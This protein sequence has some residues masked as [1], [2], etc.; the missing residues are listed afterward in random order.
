M[1]TT[2]KFYD[3][4]SLLINIKQLENQ[5]IVIS[6]ITLTELENIKSSFNKDPQIKA[7]AR[8]ALRFFENNPKDY[9]VWIY[10]VDMLDPI[11]KMGLPINEDTKILATAIDYEKRQ[12]PDD[13]TFV[14]NDL[15]L[16]HMANLFFGRDS[17]E[18]VSEEYEEYNGYQE[19]IMS[20][21]EMS[22]FYSHLDENIYDLKINEYLII[23]NEEKEIVDTLCWIGDKYRKISYHTFDSMYFGEVKPLK[24]DIY[25]NLL[26]DSLVQNKVT[27]VTGPAGT[28]KTVMSLGYLFALLEKENLNKIIVFCNTIATKNSAKLGYLPGDRN[29]KLLDSQIGNLLASKLGG[30]MVVEQLVQEEKLVLLPLSDVRGYDTSGMRAGVY[31]SEAQNMDID[32]MKLALQRIGEDSICIID[33]DLKAQVDLEEFSGYNNGMRRASEVLRGQKIYGEVALKN[34]HRSQLAKIIESM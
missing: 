30:R 5:K 7:A 22:L 24:G 1:M 14:T 33:G 12:H 3:T 6:S 26:A 16:K 27:M 32:L 10:M 34:I 29:D 18:S 21:E 4:S 28:G 9:E 17:I 13:V 11:T 31:I 23:R 8:Q 20:N 25:Q 15:A 2:Y 19:I